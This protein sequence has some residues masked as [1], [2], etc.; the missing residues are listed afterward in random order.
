VQVALVAQVGVAPLVGA[1]D[2]QDAGVA[3]LDQVVGGEDAALHL[4]DADGG[5][6]HVGGRVDQDEGEPRADAFHDVVRVVRGEQHEAV[7]AELLEAFHGRLD[8]AFPELTEGREEDLVAVR[9]GAAL[10]VLHDL[11]G[12]VLFGAVGD[13]AD[14]LGAFRDE[15]LREDARTVVE[16]LDGLQ[17]AFAGGG[18]DADV[19]VDDARHRLVR[20]AG[21]FRDVVDGDALRGGLH[22]APPASPH[23][24]CLGCSPSLLRPRCFTCGQLS[25]APGRWPTCVKVCA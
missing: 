24:S 11:R 17:H 21:A 5:T 14:Q 16:V 7:H 19:V 9:A 15:A 2:V 6:V 20:H 23:A 25:T 13:H 1:A 10:H 4:V 12:A 8:L 3:Q 18:G 22:H